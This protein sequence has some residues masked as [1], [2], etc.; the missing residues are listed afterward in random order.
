M[1]K[2][3]QDKI[4]EIVEMKL[5]SKNEAEQEELKLKVTHDVGSWYF[6]TIGIVCLTAIYITLLWIGAWF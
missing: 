5:K 4:N 2:K 1:K 3:E 6:L